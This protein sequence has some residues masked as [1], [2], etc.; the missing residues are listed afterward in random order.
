MVGASKRRF[1]DLSGDTICIRAIPDSNSSKLVTEYAGL[2]M[3][4][5]GYLSQT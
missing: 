4:L 3:A 1:P 5:I 2:F